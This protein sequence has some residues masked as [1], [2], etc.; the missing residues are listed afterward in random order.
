MANQERL[1]YPHVVNPHYT[2]QVL[3]P[4]GYRSFADFY[5]FYLGE[6]RHTV[7][8][9]LHLLGKYTRYKTLTDNDDM[10]LACTSARTGTGIALTLLLYYYATS[11][12][13]LM[14]LAFLPG[15]ALAW[16]G[17]FLFEKNRPATFKHPF[18]SLLGDLRLFYEVAS[19][20][21]AP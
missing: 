7:N 4:T 8:R 21:R 10:H 18:Y 20:L 14:P 9:R 15:Y 19:G 16:A 13:F 2:P 12:V 1:H 11:R 17:H 6:H 3:S 5:P